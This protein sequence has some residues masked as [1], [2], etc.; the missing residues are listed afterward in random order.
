MKI[1]R[2][3]IPAVLVFSV[4]VPAFAA[5]TAPLDEQIAFLQGE[6]AHIKYEIADADR[7]ETA[8]QP[9]GQ[10]A[11]QLSTAYPD[12]PEPKIWQG[13]ILATDAG[14]SGGL[15]ALSKVKAAKSL[16]EAALALDETALQGSAHTSLG[17]LYYQVPGWPIGFGDDDKAEEH[18][19]KALA[20]NPQGI[21]PN[22]FYGDFLLDQGR[23][24]EAAKVLRTALQAPDRPQRA[25]AD[26]GRREEI[27]TALAKAESKLNN[28]GISSR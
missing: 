27:K 20:I 13:I 23:Y 22:Y 19:K 6:W 11:E 18:L 16:F 15:S 3:A 28:S 2:F 12:R 17:S 1:F 8:L 5:Q 26:K 9:L 21:D 7:Q 24:K 10:R 4:A 25:L 14:I